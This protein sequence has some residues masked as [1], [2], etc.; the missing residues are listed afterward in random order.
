MSYVLLTR[1]IGENLK[2]SQ[3]IKHKGIATISSPM[4][5]L[6][7]I[8]I[9]WNLLEAY[10]Y[11]LVTSKFAA[12]LIAQNNNHKM[13]AFVVGDRSAQILAQ[14]PNIQIAKTFM[15]ANDLVTHLLQDTDV[16]RAIYIS[17]NITKTSMPDFVDTY[18]AYR[19]VYT[20][21]M[22][23]LLKKQF[24]NMKIKIVMLYS[25]NSAKIFLELCDKN[26]IIDYLSAVTAVVISKNIKSIVSEYFQRTL[27]CCKPDNSSMLKLVYDIYE[28]NL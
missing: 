19:V 4:L 13:K 28:N 7:Q 2:L 22:P 1:T 6:Y 26:S 8:P 15:N 27:F 21:K 24:M 17:G 14:N 16:T 9:N 10:P 5:K 23:I 18:L 3:E 20:S 25:E 12:Q 11:L